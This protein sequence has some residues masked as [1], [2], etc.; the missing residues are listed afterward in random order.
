MM[1][2]I[3]LTVQVNIRTRD[4]VVHGT[5]SVPELLAELAQECAEFR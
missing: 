3:V 5:K 4:N 1:V 2:L